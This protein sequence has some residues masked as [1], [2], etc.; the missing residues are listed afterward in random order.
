MRYYIEYARITFQ[1]MPTILYHAGSHFNVPMML[2][3]ARM[4][5]AWCVVLCVGQAA[6]AQT[7][8]EIIEL[9]ARPSTREVVAGERLEVAYIL[10]GST[11]GRFSIP[12]TAPFKRTS[13]MQEST[14]IQINNGVASAHHTWQVEFTAPRQ[15]GTYNLPEA[16]VVVQGKTYRSTPISIK[17]LAGSGQVSAQF[18]PVRIPE[19]A[20]PNLFVV[21]Q[22]NQTSA[23]Q[24]Q[25]VLAQVNIYT[26]L[27]VTGFDVLTYPKVSSG[28]SQ[29]IRRFDTKTRIVKIKGKSY[30]SR[31]LCML[32]LWPDQGPKVTLSPAHIRVSVEQAGSPFDQTLVLQT[33]PMSLK[34]NP[35]DQDSIP[36]DA[37]GTCG[38]YTWILDAD[39]DS[40]QVGEAINL[41][42]H[43]RGNGEPRLF[44]WPK[45]VLPDGLESFEPRTS[46]ESQNENGIEY[47]HRGTATYTILAKKPGTY[48]CSPSFSWFDPVKRQYVRWQP[49][50][51]L[52]ILVVPGPAITTTSAPTDLPRDS[53]PW[54][55]R[56]PESGQLLGIGILIF[57]LLGTIIQIAA[58]FM[59]MR[60]ALTRV[61][62]RAELVTAEP[63]LSIPTMVT[64]KPIVMTPP[65][66][67][68]NPIPTPPPTIGEHI[69]HEP[70]PA[71][72]SADVPNTPDTPATISQELLAQ[73]RRQI[74]ELLGYMPTSPRAAEAALTAQ[75]VP[76]A[77]IEALLHAWRT[78]EQVLY[79]GMQIEVA[80]LRRQLAAIS[81][82][83]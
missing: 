23:Y 53:R 7:Q 15:P 32:A 74:T 80:D 26:A 12:K 31:T 14:G 36:A 62:A 38:Q 30:A 42:V 45:L 63:P 64:K 44:K 24:G 18:G 40:V 13:S 57:I 19:G 20:D 77:Q 35:L 50:S 17:V 70:A 2:L 61:S 28:Y 29:E 1:R 43:Y 65:T 51:A 16:T 48:A 73:V 68:S 75:A 5:C 39:R 59:R 67:V 76:V 34:I 71:P 81:T 83:T 72:I 27:P 33:A 78:A 21:T 8:T 4:L 6:Y 3:R 11:E 41:T 54:L 66:P 49:D 47:I 82:N 37:V 55:D 10:S 79:A 69:S 22:L 60:K 46:D 52:N 58:W 9:S 56:L 25:Q